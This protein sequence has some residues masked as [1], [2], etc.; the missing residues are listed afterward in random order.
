MACSAKAD[1]DDQGD[2]M[3]QMIHYQDDIFFLS[4]LVKAIDSGL[5]TEADPENFRDHVIA[6][7]EFIGASL[8]T[9]GGLLT[10]N[11]LLIERAEYVKLLE[12][13]ARTYGHILERLGLSTYPGAAAY[14]SFRPRLESLE[15]TQRV[16]LA[17]LDELLSSTLV[18]E[19]ESDLVSQDELSELLRE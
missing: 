10:Q 12:R 5:S 7:L 3:P 2:S 11:V 8:Q 6:S 16:I 1:D 17:G 15:Q 13:T 14:A 18:G 9:F 4:V 19:A